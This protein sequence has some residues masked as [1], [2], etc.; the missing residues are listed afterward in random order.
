[1]FTGHREV[2]SMSMVVLPDLSM[3]TFKGWVETPASG[4]GTSQG[5]TQDT[6]S[7][8][9]EKRERDDDPQEDTTPPRG[10]ETS[11]IGLGILHCNNLRSNTLYHETLLSLLRREQEHFLGSDGPDLLAALWL[12]W[13]GQVGGWV[14][15]WEGS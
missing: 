5:H 8:G 9:K 1:M 12:I 15:L 11:A 6:T 13:D 14:G 4:T 10:F 3:V 2:K 7:A